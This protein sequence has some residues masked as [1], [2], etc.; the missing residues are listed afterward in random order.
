[1]TIEIQ[2]TQGQVTIVDDED[3]DLAQFKWSAGFGSRYANGG[4]FHA[5]RA[6]RKSDDANMSTL[7]H[8]TIMSRIVARPLLRTECVDHVN[9]NPLDNRRSNLRI[10]TVSQNMMNRQKKSGALSGFK[11]V[12]KNGGKWSANIRA[13]D[14]RIYLGMFDTPEEAHE[15][16]CKAGRELHGEF[17]NPG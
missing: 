5:K 15:A 6:K 3:G 13:N 1:M 9:G 10:A 8:R 12:S 7:M 17:F 14:K 11:G 16:Y 4:K 2:L